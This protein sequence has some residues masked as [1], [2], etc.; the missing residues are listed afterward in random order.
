M[1]NFDNS[2]YLDNSDNAVRLRRHENNLMIIGMGIMIF[3][4]WDI[5]KTMGIL[6][7]NKRIFI[8]AISENMNG[9]ENVDGVF[10]DGFVFTIFAGLV[11]SILLVSIAAR[12]IIGISAVSVARKKKKRFFYIP[13]AVLYIVSSVI[14]IYLIIQS[15][16]D[17]LSGT[18]II[19]L[20]TRDSPI[21]SVVIEITNIIMMIEVVVSSIKIRKLRKGGEDKDAA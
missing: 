7:L 13:V 21:V 5:A 18:D 3:G 20:E 9:V 19:V 4:M 17:T 15:V 14:T 1:M 11:I 10:S 6:F 8:D 16:V 2:L 12:L